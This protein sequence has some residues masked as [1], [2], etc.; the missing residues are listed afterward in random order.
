MV[1]DAKRKDD[2]ASALVRAITDFPRRL[3]GD[4]EGMMMM[5]N[6]GRA[7]SS[8]L[9]RVVAVF[10][11]AVCSLQRN[12]RFVDNEEDVESGSDRRKKS[13]SSGPTDD[14]SATAPF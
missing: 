12:R 10:L 13:R 14:P 9:V 4:D 3:K 6:D 5:M 2:I 7:F 1:K 11:L 8:G